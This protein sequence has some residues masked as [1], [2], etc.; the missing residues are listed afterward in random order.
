MFR[1]RSLSL[2]DSPL[3]QVGPFDE[4]KEDVQEAV[5]LSL[6]LSLTHLCSKSGRLMRLKRMFR[7]RSLSLSPSL[8]LTFVLSRVV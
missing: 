4:V 3:F 2:S 7:R 1:R 6:S 5:S 8:L